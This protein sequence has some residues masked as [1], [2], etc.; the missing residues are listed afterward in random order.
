MH[1]V[2]IL[3]PIWKDRS[4]GIAEE[5][6]K[7]EK[8][9]V[10]IAYRDKTGRQIYPDIYEISGREL[11]TYPRRKFGNTPMLYIVPI[12]D[13]KIKMPEPVLSAEE[14]ARQDYFR[15]QGL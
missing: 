1:K 15:T 3:V 14:K 11:K 2:I 5:Y 12:K 7:Q 9:E 4:I 6:A 13:L 8:L 10:E